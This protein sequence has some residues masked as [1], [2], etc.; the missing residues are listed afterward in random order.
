MTPRID[1]TVTGV[2]RVWQV[3]DMQVESGH[4]P[5]YVAAVRIRGAEHVRAGGRT[6]LE[7]TSPPM[8]DDTQFRIA[9]IT[10]P[11][12]AALTLALVRDGVVALDDPI[13]R[14]LPE[15]AEPRVLVAA[16]GALDDTV[17]A[18][19]AITVRDLLA[20]TSGW[21]IVM[22]QGPL[23]AEMMERGVYGSPL[24]RDV[25]PDE[26]VERVTSLPL[27][28]QPGAGWLYETGMDLLG[29]LLVR[30]TGRSLADL[31]AER[32]TG[33]L[34][35]TST[36]FQ[37][38]DAARLATAYIPGPDGLTVLDPPHGTFAVPPPFEELSSGLV[39]TA[40][41]VLRFFCA[42]AD[43]GAPV[44]TA[45]EVALMTADALTPEQRRSA[46]VFL[47]RG[48]SWGLGTG[49]DV[50]AEEPWQAPGRWGWTGGT[51]TTAYVDPVRATVA[52]LMTQRAMTGPLDGFDDFWTAVAAAA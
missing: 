48:E 7:P 38:T 3:L 47:G 52:V 6:A 23:Q 36:G 25:S 39:S 19:R 29:M 13:G 50:R 5:G 34:G 18:E 20:G 10:K 46:L 30:A 2:E 4:L 17:P 14:W 24:H 31:V 35:L 49:V 32:I 21:G 41:E 33:P 28:F 43:G 40:P 42:M 9:S 12:G 44:L 27:A 1:S 11:V 26:F 8:R 37:A 16:D 22:E 15:A 45:D 51:G